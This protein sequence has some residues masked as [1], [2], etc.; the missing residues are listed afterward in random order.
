MSRR[1]SITSFAGECI[2]KILCARR[3]SN[4]NLLI[5]SQ[6]LYPLSYGRIR[7]ATKAMLPSTISR[8][9][10]GAPHAPQHCPPLTQTSPQVTEQHL[11]SSG[12]SRF[13]EGTETRHKIASDSGLFPLVNRVVNRPNANIPYP[14]TPN[15]TLRNLKH[16]ILIFFRMGR[17]QHEN[18]FLLQQ[19]CFC[20]Q[21]PPKG[22]AKESAQRSEKH[23]SQPF[24]RNRC[25]DI[26]A[27]A[28]GFEPAA[29]RDNSLAG[30]PI[31][32]LWHA[33]IRTVAASK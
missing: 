15:S 10:T 14:L 24:G 33:S 25:V 31:R 4:P 23:R 29:R 3:D 1:I 22:V 20:T 9:T 28:T 6:M 18:Q 19:K 8:T 2:Q 32:P 27:E 21:H 26:L 13:A 16:G 17:V 12:A 7:L 5:R 11:S 30:S